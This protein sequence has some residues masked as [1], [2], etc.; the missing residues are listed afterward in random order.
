MKRLIHY[1]VHQP[2][3]IVLGTLLFA[4]A[5][6]IAFSRSR[7]SIGSARPSMKAASDSRVTDFPRVAASR[8]DSRRRDLP[9]ARG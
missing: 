7:S 3:F 2:L 1:A 5:G 9:T 4:L 8:H 6:V